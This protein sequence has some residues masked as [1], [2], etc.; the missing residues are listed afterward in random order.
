VTE[1]LRFGSSPVCR[2]RG[3]EGGV[4]GTSSVSHTQGDASV[5]LPLGC[6]W[7]YTLAALQASAL[8]LQLVFIGVGSQ[9]L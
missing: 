1:P 2:E 4:K 9:R 3:A 5:A 6:P 8:T 7:G